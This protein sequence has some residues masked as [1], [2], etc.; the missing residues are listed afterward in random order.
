MNYPIQLSLFNDYNLDDMESDDYEEAYF[1]YLLDHLDQEMYDKDETFELS[2]NDDGN[3][4]T[5]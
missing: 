1:N 2:K 3:P 4:L 5:S